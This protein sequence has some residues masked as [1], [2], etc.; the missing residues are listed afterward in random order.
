[1]A[2][3]AAELA[4]EMDVWPMSRV[5]ASSSQSRTCWRPSAGMPS[6]REITSTGK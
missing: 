2:T 4:S 3:M 5:S 6:I 1:M